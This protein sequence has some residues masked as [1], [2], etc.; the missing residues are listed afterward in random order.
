[1]S[2]VYQKE[3]IIWEYLS[4]LLSQSERPSIVNMSLSGTIFVNYL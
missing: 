3:A 1:M 2:L 4:D